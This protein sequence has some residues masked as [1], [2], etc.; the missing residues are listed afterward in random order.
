MD[1]TDRLL[2]TACTALCAALM[3]GCAA[4][5]TLRAPGFYLSALPV[6]AA[7][8]YAAVLV[9][10][11][12]RGAAWGIGA[13]AGIGIPCAFLLAARSS[14]MMQALHAA[15]QSE[16]AG[17]LSA[18]G[19]AALNMALLLALMLG[20]LFALL[21]RMRSG[22]PFTLLVM[23]AVVICALAINEDISIWAALPALAA[24]VAAFA[25]HGDVR[26]E[27]LRPTLM[28]PA[29]A[30]TLLALLLT[31]STRTTWQP[32]EELAERIRAITQDYMHFTEERLAFSINEKGYDHA[33][34]IDDDV[35]AML[36]GPAEPDEERVMRVES[37]TT[38]LLRGTIKRS[39]TGYSW[40]DDQTKA[41]YLYYDFIHSGVR[42]DVFDADSTDGL[43]GFSL[44]NV[45]V[46]MLENGTSTLFVSGQMDQFE[47]DLENAVY[48]NSAGEL[49]LTR[50]VEPGDSYAFTVRLPDSD[51]ALVAACLQR[52]DAQDAGYGAAL[53]DYTA[54]PEGID[55]RVYALA[56]EL[57]QNETS[58][59]GKALAIQEYL[60]QNYR[61]TLNGSYPRQGEDF[62]SWFLLESKE[63]YC[64]YY[65]SAMAVLCRIAG[66]PARYV[67]GYYVRA[68]AE[69]ETFVSGQNAHAWVEVYL[70]GLGWIA[71]DPTA[72]SVEN[73]G[74]D[75]SS[76][77]DN[78]MDDSHVADEFAQDDPYE[79]DTEPEPTPTPSPAPDEGAQVPSDAP[80]PTPDPD[81]DENDADAPNLPPDAENDA[82]EKP[83]SD[84]RKKNHAWLW[85]LL[86]LVVLALIALAV[87][88]LRRRLLASDPLKMCASVRSGNQAAMI[89][90][91]S[92]LT[93]LLQIGLNPANGETPHAFASRASAAIANPAYERFVCGVVNSRYSGK[94]IGR[95][96]IEDGREAYVVFLNGMRRSE[97]M[98]FHLRRALHGLG[99]FENIP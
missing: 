35:V 87:L 37:D 38:L 6:Y 27:G 18:Y 24:G 86:I 71:F 96:T 95:E 34:M 72:R 42:D 5:L 1:K 36:G 91:R 70:N 17:G 22:A 20:A 33:G 28:L 16:A 7:A 40:V 44:H 8:L 10:L 97:K 32:L 93:L 54:L 98:R 58:A 55:S 92:I 14:E 89:L 12:Q 52:A 65:A 81:G 62:V 21:L 29:V 49:F 61:Y 57:T 64:S 19:G 46:E 50:E 45:R 3:A 68:N 15:A 78:G 59:A 60:A 11:A 41:R 69:G 76:Q 26:R 74:G 9:Q 84:E 31:P 4:Y 53:A 88:W 80:T 13:A 85:I 82:R 30:L 56:V 67:E 47:M 48:Y 79:G 51:E 75:G 99:N 43:D 63:G 2:R 39:Y 77:Q 94:N 90:Y 73:G 83:D 23:L 66:L 25:L